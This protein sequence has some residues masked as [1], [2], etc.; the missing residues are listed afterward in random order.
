MSPTIFKYK[1]YKFSFFS[2]EEKRMHV[3]VFCSEGEA[4]IW[5]EPKVELAVQ[6]GLNDREIKD[7]LTAAEERSHEIK[8][9]WKK[10][11]SH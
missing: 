10:H 5:M 3:H 8:K 11:F 7:I 6:K 1:K 4:K 9:S 2:R